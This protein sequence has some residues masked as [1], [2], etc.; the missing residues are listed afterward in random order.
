MMKSRS[1]K[2]GKKIHGFEEMS[3]R[4]FFWQGRAFENA[5]S[6]AILDAFGSAFGDAQWIVSEGYKIE[7]WTAS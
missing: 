3:G 6:D 4:I 7:I 1:L 2:A 5:F